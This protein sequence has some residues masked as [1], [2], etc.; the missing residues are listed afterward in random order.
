MFRVELPAL[1]EQCYDREWKFLDF[2]ILKVLC[3]CPTAYST[4]VFVY[5]L[6]NSGFLK[7]MI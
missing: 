3:C 6:D 2:R 1:A 4:A 7:I 5:I